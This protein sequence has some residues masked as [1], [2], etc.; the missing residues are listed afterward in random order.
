MS[1][2]NNFVIENGILKKYAGTDN[3]VV[4][5]DSVTEI[6]A[7]AFRDC[8]SLTQITI[9]IVSQRLAVPCL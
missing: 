4:I 1:N 3:N 9:R 8:S 2:E 6:G 7:A 5:P